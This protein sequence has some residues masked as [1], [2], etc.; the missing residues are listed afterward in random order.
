MVG[1]D[2]RRRLPS[3]LVSRCFASRPHA[4]RGEAVTR[5]RFAAVVIGGT[6]ALVFGWFLVGLFNRFATV[7]G[8][9]PEPNL[10]WILSGLGLI[11]LVALLP[12]VAGGMVAA[13]DRRC[14]G[15]AV[16]PPGARPRRILP[17]V[18]A[19]GVRPGPRRAE[20]GPLLLRRQGQEPGSGLRAGLHRGGRVAVRPV[21]GLGGWAS[22]RAP[23]QE[24]KPCYFW[25]MARAVIRI[26]I[27][28][29]TP[30]RS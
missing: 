29:R 12:F 21:R 2:P 28:G 13:G 26:Q 30:I 24:L 5:M 20:G 9:A 15:G 22:W 1:E 14:F 18:R 3:F 6:V 4:T 27:F 19:G 25:P 10:A 11:L 7:P 8:G 23:K 16:R 17:G